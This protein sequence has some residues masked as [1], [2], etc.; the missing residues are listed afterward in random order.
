MVELAVET[1]GGPWGRIEWRPRGRHLPP[2][3]NCARSYDSC[4]A[5]VSWIPPAEL[6][7]HRIACDVEQYDRPVPHIMAR[8]FGD[9]R[10][11]TFFAGWTAAEVA[12][13]LTGTPI[14]MW[15]RERGLATYHTGRPFEVIAGE[16]A[17]LVGDP[18]HRS[19]G[20][21]RLL[22]LCLPAQRSW[23][24]VGYLRRLLPGGTELP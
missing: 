16:R 24:T 11:E 2:S 12:A 17:D 3:S 8:R 10:A 21:C 23:V 5:Q 20:A 15:L 19:E 18:H 13:K 4:G 6:W 1:Y 14:L 7:S 9:L 22:T